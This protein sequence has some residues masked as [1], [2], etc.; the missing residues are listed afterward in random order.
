MVIVLNTNLDKAGESVYWGGLVRTKYRYGIRENCRVNINYCYLFLQR[1]AMLCWSPNEGG[2][3]TCC[4]NV[5][6]ISFSLITRFLVFKSL[7][8]KMFYKFPSSKSCDK[9]I[10]YSTLH[11]P[12]GR[13]GLLFKCYYKIRKDQILHRNICLFKTDVLCVEIY[14][15]LSRFRN[16]LICIIYFWPKNWHP[17]LIPDESLFVYTSQLSSKLFIPSFNWSPS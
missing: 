10:L 3:I 14:N 5:L 8:K 16:L 12:H 1:A 2:L 15:T 17:L 6:I 4:S 7:C 13:H 9:D 11:D